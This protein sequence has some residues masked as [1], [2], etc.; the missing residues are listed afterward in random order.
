MSYSD[1]RVAFRLGALIQSV[2]DKVIYA[3][4]KVAELS[5]ELEKLSEALEEEDRE[6]VKSWLEYLRDHYSGLDELDPD[7][8]KALVKD[9]GTVR[10]TIES[11]IR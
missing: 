5:R 8:R 7:D 9:L 6:L 2:E 3:R 1:P 11:K 4:P 10:E